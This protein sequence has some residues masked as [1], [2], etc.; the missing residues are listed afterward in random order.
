MTDCSLDDWITKTKENERPKRPWKWFG[1][2]VTLQVN[3]IFNWHK[4]GLKDSLDFAVNQSSLFT[5]VNYNLYQPP[6]GFC[7]DIYCNDEPIID[8]PKS[9][10]YNVEQRVDYEKFIHC[11]FK[12]NWLNTSQVTDFLNYCEEQAN[13]YATDSILLTMGSDFHY[14]DANVWFKNMDKLI[15]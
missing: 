6:P 14:Q 4:N 9:K 8:D 10:D 5:A 7:F 13:A 12:I 15:K 2:R 11:I 3:Y 1:K